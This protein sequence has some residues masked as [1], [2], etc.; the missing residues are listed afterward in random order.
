[1]NFLQL[2]YAFNPK[3]DER[4]PRKGSSNGLSARYLSKKNEY[5]S[6]ASFIKCNNLTTR[7][8]GS[9]G[10]SR[11]VEIVVKSTVET[12]VE[13]S[14]VWRESETVVVCVESGEQ[15][16]RPQTIARVTQ[17]RRAGLRWSR[18]ANTVTAN[19]SSKSRLAT[20]SRISNYSTCKNIY[21]QK[22]SIGY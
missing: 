17:I 11:T 9:G 8:C 4:R 18:D 22:S 13:T 16:T 3:N 1:M 2:L 21:R 12:S 10:V 6:L 5:K 7:A 14:I 15:D 19:C 20:T